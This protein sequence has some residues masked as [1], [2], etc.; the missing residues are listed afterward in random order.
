MASP[1]AETFLWRRISKDEAALLRPF[2]ARPEA[3]AKPIYRL[4]S[5]LASVF[6]PQ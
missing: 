6:T 5:P 3:V 4:A 1:E 2:V